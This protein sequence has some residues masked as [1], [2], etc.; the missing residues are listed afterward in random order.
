MEV[1]LTVLSSSR[2]QVEASS[3]EHSPIAEA[4]PRTILLVKDAILEVGKSY[5]QGPFCGVYIV[6]YVHPTNIEALESL[7]RELRHLVQHFT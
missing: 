5:M 1:C 7:M 3:A 4:A 2:I 6:M